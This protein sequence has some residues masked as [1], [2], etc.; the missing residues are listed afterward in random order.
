MINEVKEIKKISNDVSN[1]KIKG[2]ENTQTDVTEPRRVSKI[3]NDLE[4]K[5]H[6]VTGVPY[7]SRKFRLNGEKVEGVFPR[8][9]SEFDDRLPK[10]LWRASDPE[11]FK[12]CTVKLKQQTE[13]NPEFAKKFTPKQLEQ[14]KNVSPKIAGL[15]WHHNEV[16]GRMQLVDSK[17]HDAS[18][19]TG[20][21]NIW[22]GGSGAR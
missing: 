10:A 18:G 17:I 12:Y 21:R 1:N 14:I 2:Y 7:V 11:H 20:G 22:G 13:M 19:H 9:K 16:P 8:F 4:G 15:T 6:P 5:K 3:N